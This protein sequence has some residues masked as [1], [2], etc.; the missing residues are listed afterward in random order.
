MNHGAMD[1]D[2]P[3]AAPLAEA[4]TAYL[5]LHDALA[6]DRLEGVAGSAR[7]FGDAFTRAIQMPPPGAPHFWHMRSGQTDDVEAAA[8]RLT[9]SSDLSSARFAFGAL[10]A[11]FAS[12]LEAHEMPGGF[13]LVRHTCGMQPDAPEGG[14]WLQRE[15][16]VRNPYFGAAMQMCARESHPA[17]SPTEAHGDHR[18]TPRSR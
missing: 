1:S 6:S 18:M 14:V 17:S 3:V 2:A 10:S 9:T 12:L 5:A 16:E 8:A 13:N 11:P 7:A 15:G 4:L